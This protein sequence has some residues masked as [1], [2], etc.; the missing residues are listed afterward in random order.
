MQ[1]D[2]IR[3]TILDVDTAAIS[4]PTLNA[5]RKMLV[6]IGDAPVVFVLKFVVLAIRIRVAP[7][8]EGFDKLVS[9]FIIRELGEGLTLVIGNDPAHIFIQPLLVFA[10]QLSL[11]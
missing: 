8:P 10:F 5:G 1:L 3:R 4:P 7:L 11:Q 9:L 2:L 6:S